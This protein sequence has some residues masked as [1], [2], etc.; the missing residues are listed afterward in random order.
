MGVGATLEYFSKLLRSG[1]RKEEK[2]E[3]E[4]KKQLQTVEL[5]V[6]MDC[7]GCELKIKKAL[8]SLK[9]LILLSVFLWV[10]GGC[11]FFFFIR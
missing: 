4:K 3:K 6:K 5:K 8:S 9:G 1:K 2:E 11:T 10:G 7:E